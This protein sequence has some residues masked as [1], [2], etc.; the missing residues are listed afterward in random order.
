MLDPNRLRAALIRLT[1]VT[2][3]SIAAALPPGEARADTAA[4]EVLFQEGR[5]LMN[6]GRFAEACPKLKESH[7]IDPGVGVLLY[8]GDCYAGNG[9]TAS[10]WSTY[11]EAEAGA[12]T[13][14]QVDREKIARDKAA[15]LEP[16][17]TRVL[18]LAPASPTPGLEVRIDEQ[19]FGSAMMGVAI[20]VD[21]GTVQLTVTAPGKERWSK[22][23]EIAPGGGEIRVEL[24]ALAATTGAA[25]A[26]VA[27][28]S[29]SPDGPVD[30]DGWSGQKTAAAVVL[31]VGVAGIAVG[32]I[33]GIMAAGSWSDADSLCGEGD[34][35]QCTEEGAVAG[36]GAST[37]ALVSTVG[38][39]V[40]LAAVVGAG[41]LWFTAP[42]DGEQAVRV[43][44]R[45]GLGGGGI[46]V[47][48]R[49]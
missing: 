21:P 40:G 9:Q 25:P 27:D 48:G 36:E 22:T 18:L 17:L 19:Q 5:R 15:A 2:V 47:G 44:P 32:S 14:R 11:R 16:K 26:A 1:L 10:A 34:P 46:E 41:V 43:T 20:P 30:Q 8:L 3:S 12:R 24:P 4:A 35:R 45:V 31:G 37:E 13:A 7:R 29:Q 49:F 42:D 33:F 23:L 38:F 39:G 28:P 6:E